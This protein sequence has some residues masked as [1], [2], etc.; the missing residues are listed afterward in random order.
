MKKERVIFLVICL[1][2]VIGLMVIGLVFIR[3]SI[4]GNVTNEFGSKLI[5]YSIFDTIR[6]WLFGSS[7]EIEI[8][9]EMMLGPGDVAPENRTA[10]M[11]DSWLVLYNLNDAESIAWKDWYAQQWGIPPENTLGLD[12]SLNEKILRGP[13]YD[14]ANIS[15]LGNIADG[16]TIEIDVTGLNIVY[17]FDTDITAN[18]RA[19]NVRVNVTGGTSS[20][21]AAVALDNAIRN[22]GP[23]VPWGSRVYAVG[24]GIVPLKWREGVGGEIITNNN[25]ANN[26][27]NVTNFQR[28][29][30]YNYIDDIFDPVNETLYNNQELRAKIMGILVGYRVPGNFY[31]DATHP[32]NQGGGGAS[33]SNNLADLT[34]TNIYWKN[35]PY[36]FQAYYMSPKPRIT[37]ATL[38][39]D[40]YITARIDA[41]TLEEAKN[42]TRRA[43]AITYSNKS[44]SGWIYYDYTDIGSLPGDDW[45]GLNLTVNDNNF[46]NS[47][48]YPWKEY[49]SETD[50]MSD[51]AFSFSYYRFSGWNGV[52]FGSGEGKPGDRILGYAFNSWGATTVRSTTNLE[53]RYVPN[54]LFR[55]GYAAAVG[56]TSEPLT[57]HV[58]DPG[59]LLWDLQEGRTLGEAMFHANQNLD[60]VWEVVGDPLLRVPYWFGEEV[61]CNN[62]T[63]E[64][65]CKITRASWEL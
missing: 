50:N 61:G 19:G 20:Y 15:L 51:D 62:C 45:R 5:G 4:N 35:N 47:T 41:P 23:D 64:Q 28:L 30:Y 57:S 16:D 65:K 32:D 27:I 22:Y 21:D 58:V 55:G 11:P 53:G 17:E 13:V 43:L 3:G 29:R 25:D 49:E 33:V 14:E 34:T 60:F 59:T 18:V 26:V 12:A 10:D 36:Y 44:L 46:S 2:L 39:N 24:S 31:V 8:E 54:A 40:T 6:N 9:N 37:K 52:S 63:Q 7:E 56:A 42:L 1:L 38:E 48:K